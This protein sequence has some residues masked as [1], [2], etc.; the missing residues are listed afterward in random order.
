MAMAVVSGTDYA[1]SRHLRTVLKGAGSSRACALVTRRA[2]YFVPFVSISGGGM[3]I[4]RTTV[5][6]GGVSPGVYVAQLLADPQTTADALDAALSRH[7]S[8]VEG[9]L[10]RPLEQFR[11]IKIRTGLLSRAVRLSQRADGLWGNPLTENF[12]WRP[13][14]QDLPAFIEFFAG[15]PRLV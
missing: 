15:D 12:G 13:A 1:F 8:T 10:A 9:A 2:L 6:I 11:R 3:S 4:V 5:T 14:K 7:C